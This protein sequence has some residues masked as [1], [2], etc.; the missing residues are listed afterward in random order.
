MKRISS[1]FAWFILSAIV[2]AV[3]LPG[4]SYADILPPAVFSESIETGPPPLVIDTAGT[5]NW[6]GCPYAGECG[7]DTATGSYGTAGAAASV[8]G[9]ASGGSFSGGTQGAEVVYF[10]EVV[11][12]NVLVPLLLT[13]SGSTAVSGSGGANAYIYTGAVGEGG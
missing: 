2:A 1:D 7:S 3:S 9:S 13:Y 6:S 10:Y 11:G 8:A 4:A 12:G 5:L